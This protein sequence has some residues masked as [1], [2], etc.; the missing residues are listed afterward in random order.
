VQVGEVRCRGEHISLRPYTSEGGGRGEPC[1]SPADREK[2]LLS[3]AHGYQENHFAAA[4]VG[5]EPVVCCLNDTA[6]YFHRKVF[7]NSFNY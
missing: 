6:A 2:C 4:C 7:S 1:V 3:L 5:R